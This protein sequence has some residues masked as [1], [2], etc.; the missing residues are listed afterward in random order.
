M[1]GHCLSAAGSVESVMQYCIHQ[2]FIFPNNINLE[3]V[4]ESIIDVS[5]IPQRIDKQIKYNSKKKPV[6]VW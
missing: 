2:G 5:R 4:G 6:L 3:L 1:V